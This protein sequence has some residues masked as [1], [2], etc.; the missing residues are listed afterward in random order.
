[1]WML[2][3]ER[4]RER[5]R[6]RRR[7]G[8]YSNSKRTI[9]AA[10]PPHPIILQKKNRFLLHQQKDEMGRKSPYT[11]EHDKEFLRNYFVNSICDRDLSERVSF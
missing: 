1:M 2:E 11:Q 5:E 4:E 8:F 3:R 10:K 7:T 9:W 6:R